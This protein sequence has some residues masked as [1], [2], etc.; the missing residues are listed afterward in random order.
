MNVNKLK[1]NSPLYKQYLST[2][3]D[4]P[5]Q[6]FYLGQIEDLENIPK[7]AIVGSRKV[8]TYGRAVTEKLAGQL[9]MGG[10]IIVSGLA[11]GVDSLAHKACLESG[12]KTIAVLPSSV[13]KIYPASHL[14]LAKQI[15]NQGGAIFSEYSGSGLPQKFQFIARNRIIAALADVVIIT[16]A[17]HRSGSLHTANFALEQGKTV[18][19]VPGNIYSPNSIGT[20][21]LIKS[22]ALPVTEVS[23]IWH[24]LGLDPLNTK[25]LT[26][27]NNPNEASILKL[28]NLGISDGTE[29]LEKSQL[30][31][32]EFSQ[33]LTM[34][35]ISGKIRPLGAGHWTLF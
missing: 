30:N 26:I 10:A 35:E 29:L 21:Q 3:A 33:T 16:E 2:I 12:G 23:D 32:I 24:E 34:L 4:P 17:A 14:H 22:G 11:L 31:P 28:I 20:N 13:N 27:A 15:L 8:S 9:A 6:I 7:I 5:Q 18:M 19:A 25:T 1:L